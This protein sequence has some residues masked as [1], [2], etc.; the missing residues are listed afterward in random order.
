MEKE[1]ELEASTLDK[2]EIANCRDDLC[3]DI[4]C[5]KARKASRLWLERAT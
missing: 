4:E 1:A 2:F 3:N 5:I